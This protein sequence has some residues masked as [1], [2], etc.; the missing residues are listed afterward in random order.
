MIDDK[1]WPANM[2]YVR[3]SGSYVN[4]IVQ[5]NLDLRKA[6]QT[7]TNEHL[8]TNDKTTK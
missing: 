3:C 1:Q 7:V 8:I 6:L 4:P 5:T 2:T